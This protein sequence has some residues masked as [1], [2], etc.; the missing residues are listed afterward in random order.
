MNK[1]L[2]IITTPYFFDKE[3]T[4]LNSLFMEGMQHLHLRKPECA[5][6]ELERLLDRISPEFY[7]RIVLHD[8]FEL[9]AER[10]LGGIHL[11]R[12]NNL[13]P[14]EYNGS[15]SRSCHS[16]DEIKAMKSSF[17][18][19]FLSPIFPSI[20]KEG[21]GNGFNLSELQAAKDIIDDKVIA[22][23]GICAQTLRQL[24]DIP[25]GGA[26]VLGALWGKQPS[27]ATTNHIVEQFKKLQIWP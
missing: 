1:R 12:R 18:Y 19:L 10:H 25:F 15:L 14:N 26:A 24:K 7:P 2:I 21:Y 16:L 8:H 23:G 11:N 9:A 6:A 20:S 27:L 5:R 17:D 13:R 22:L 3:A 4:L